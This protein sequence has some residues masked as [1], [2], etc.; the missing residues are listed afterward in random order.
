MARFD[1]RVAIVTGAG[2]GIGLAVARALA[3]EGACVEAVDLKDPILGDIGGTLKFRRCDLTDDGDVANV[4]EQIGRVHG[5]LDMVVNCAGICLFERDGSIATSNDDVL[6]LTLDVN[7]RGVIRVIRAAIPLLKRS[8]GGSMVHVASVV[9]IR[10]MEN[11]LEGGPSDAYQISKAALVSLSRSLAMQ[12]AVDGIRSNTVCPGAVD[13][14][15]TGDIYAQKER[16]QRME[17]RTPLGRI[18]K[19]EDIANAILFL[20]SDEADFIT[21]IDLPVDG[22]LLAKL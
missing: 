9:G 1:G 17:N 19:P 10:N 22:G 8:G 14:P 20:L 6:D 5:K 4:L 18:A 2:G 13:T 11:I 3:L 7:L 16:V 15:M 12:F 21:G